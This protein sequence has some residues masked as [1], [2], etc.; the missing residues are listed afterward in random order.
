M[1]Q[2]GYRLMRGRQGASGHIR[3]MGD[4]GLLSAGGLT[5]GER[6]ALRALP[7]GECL[8]EKAADGEGCVSFACTALG[9]VFLARG[10]S[11]VLWE[12]EEQGYWMACGC[13]QQ[14][15]K[16]PAALASPAQEAAPPAEEAPAAPADALP[17]SPP[18]PAQRSAVPLRSPGEGAPVDALPAL[19]WPRGTEAIRRYRA[20]CPPIRPFDEPGWRFVRTPSPIR[21]AAYCAVGWRTED[22][23]V[24]GVAYAVPGSAYRPPAP[25]PGY[26][27]RPGRQGIGYWVIFKPV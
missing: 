6:Y 21:Q 20:S 3:E 1:A 17:P 12:G 26:R 15:K 16:A 7:G 27:Y 11:V 2:L 13:L 4:G 9:P 10:S 25:L 8:Q 24:T 5:P 18:R 22:G 23:R 19:L 14:E